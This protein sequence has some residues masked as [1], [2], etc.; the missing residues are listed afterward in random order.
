MNNEP[1]HVSCGSVFPTLMAAFRRIKLVKSRPKLA[2]RKADTTSVIA[3]IDNGPKCRPKSITISTDNSSKVTSIYRR[4]TSRVVNKPRPSYHH[5]NRF[6]EM[7]SQETGLVVTGLLIH[8]MSIPG[9][10]TS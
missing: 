2:G 3:D 9:R 8:I 1:S 6:Q 5:G 7:T 10:M 4:P